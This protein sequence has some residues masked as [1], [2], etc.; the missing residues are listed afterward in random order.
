LMSYVGIGGA[1]FPTLST[2]SVSSI[3][4]H[5]FELS[6]QTYVSLLRFDLLKSVS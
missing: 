6:R 3:G 4:V 2:S 1:T 5:R